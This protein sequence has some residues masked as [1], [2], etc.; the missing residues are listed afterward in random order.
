MTQLL[1]TLIKLYQHTLSPDHGWPQG[2]YP[3]G[4]CR[5]YPSCSQYAHDAI[6]RYGAARGLFLATRRIIRCNPW[7]QA[8]VDQIPLH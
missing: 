2:R 1:Q 4:F 5:F 8:R 3:Y 7:A 6:G